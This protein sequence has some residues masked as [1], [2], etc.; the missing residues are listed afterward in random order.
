MCDCDLDA[1]TFY[2]SEHVK[3]A[4]RIHRCSECRRDIQIGESYEKIAGVWDSRFEEFKVCT[5]CQAVRDWARAQTDCF[6]P[7]LGGL[8]EEIAETHEYFQ[9]STC[10]HPDVVVSLAYSLQRRIDYHIKLQAGHRWY[11]HTGWAVCGCRV[12]RSIARSL[13]RSAR[14][15]QRASEERSPKG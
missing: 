15:I 6:C 1:P 4:R 2:S 12:G 8:Y 5:W 11:S 7:A 14:Q 10:P 13:E 9:L 3:R